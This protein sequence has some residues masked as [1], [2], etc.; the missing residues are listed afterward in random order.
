MTT[1]SKPVKTPVVAG[2]LTVHIEGT[3]NEVIRCVG[4]LTSENHTHLKELVRPLIFPG[5]R[6]T[7][8]FSEL[9][10]LDSAG[11]GAIVGL[12]VSSKTHRCQLEFVNLNPRIRE[13]LGMTNLLGAFESA[14]RHGTKF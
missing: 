9:V 8:D 12:Y 10:Y 6:I 14:A 11:L 13:L 5:S 1:H 2:A 3:A 4:R 7:L